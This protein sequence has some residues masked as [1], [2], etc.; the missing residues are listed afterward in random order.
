MIKSCI[1]FLILS[2]FIP[3]TAA[4]AQQNASVPKIMLVCSGR[5]SASYHPSG[6]GYV[7][8][9]R[10]GVYLEFINQE[11]TLYNIGFLAAPLPDALKLTIVSSNPGSV[12]FRGSKYY[13][14]L[15]GNINRVSGEI[16]LF[17]DMGP[18]YAT[19]K[20]LC[21]QTSKKVF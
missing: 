7:P 4:T 8:P 2:S 9:L 16:F 19:F 18:R 11:A 17:D 14:R 21:N 20:G 1:R 6:V 13:E 5:V 3:S 10:E 12:R 15:T